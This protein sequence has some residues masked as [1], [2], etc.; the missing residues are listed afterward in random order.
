MATTST[1][2]PV[3]EPTTP[4][5]GAT[6]AA[7]SS[8]AGTG[9]AGGAAAG[10]T[11]PPAGPPPLEADSPP[12][13]TATAVGVLAA[14]SLIAV[15][16]VGLMVGAEF[17]FPGGS[18]EGGA[19]GGPASADT[20]S[21]SGP[22]E[23]SVTASEFAFAPS[24]L[25]LAG[26]GEL[27]VTLD[28]TGVVEHDLVIEGIDGRALAKAGE[29]A[30]GIFQLDRPGTYT[31]YCSIPGHRDAGMEGTLAVAG[32]AAAVSD[33]QTPPQAPGAE[34]TAVTAPADPD[35]K[36]LPLP[37]VAPPVNRTTPAI[38]PVHI[39]TQEITATLADGVTHTYWT[40][41]GT[42]PGPMIRVRQGDTVELTLK[43]ALGSS[44][45]HSIDLHAV[46]GPGG[47]AKVMQVPPGEERTFRFKALNPGVYIYHCATPMVAHH[48]AM[49]MYGLIVVEP[50]EGLPPVDREFY[51]VQGDIYV[52]GER[53]DTG[54]REFSLDK[55]LDERAD[56][57]VFNGRVGAL[58]G[59][60]ALKAK[61]GETVRIF[62]GVGGPNLT[63]SFHVIGEIFD[64]M[65]PEGASEP[66]TN[67]QTTLVPAGGA[68]MVEFTVEVPG[69]YILVDHSLSRLEK[70]AGGFLVVEGPAAPDIFQSLN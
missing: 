51:V 22:A 6:S 48:I 44:V 53:G 20:A 60:G 31:Y 27:T 64:R 1:P 16:V 29:T 39:E 56:Y 2:S 32:S 45:T 54:H 63:S 67:V 69:T 57:V 9:G 66:A 65:Y 21:T 28:N 61:V 36:P 25:R 23:I 52:Q 10:G 38:V 18:Q 34:T 33:V 58:T 47:G 46:T 12:L 50:P 13:I 15:L 30:S 49:G 24:Q 3:E 11:S 43:N 8:G 4:E 42:V 19:V 35:A 14:F 55:M 41:N 7:P 68:T 70:G 59:D 62:F 17:G 26:P 40:F 5:A 37:V